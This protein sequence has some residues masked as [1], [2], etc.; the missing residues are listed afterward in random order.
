MASLEAL[1]SVVTELTKQAAMKWTAEEIARVERVC[2]RLAKQAGCEVTVPLP[3]WDSTDMGVSLA[4]YVGV[5]G[6]PH[7]VTASFALTEREQR[8]EDQVA[9]KTLIATQ[10]I[11]ALVLCQIRPVRERPAKPV[12]AEVVGEG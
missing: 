4:K 1:K 2:R 10:A 5:R 8:D 11:D 12:A 3:C 6:E 9:A 7:K